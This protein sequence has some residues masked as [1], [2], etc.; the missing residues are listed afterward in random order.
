MPQV[1]ITGVNSAHTEI[2][3]NV[4]WNDRSFATTAI[5]TAA[6]DTQEASST[7]LAHACASVIEP[8]TNNSSIV[9]IL[10]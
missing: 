10:M 9:S 6:A 2:V 1:A 8:V 7:Y 3:S 5:D 4:I